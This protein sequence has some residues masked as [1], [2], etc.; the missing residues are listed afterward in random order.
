MSLSQCQN[1]SWEVKE[2][3]IVVLSAN[4]IQSDTQFAKL[5]REGKKAL[6][7]IFCYQNYSDLL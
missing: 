2:R 5:P 7:M 1:I 4:L 3:A 6:I